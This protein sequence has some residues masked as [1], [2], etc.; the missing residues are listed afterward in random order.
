MSPVNQLSVLAFAA[1]ALAVPGFRDFGHRHSHGHPHGHSYGSAS[2][3][4]APFPA[5]NATGVW[6]STGSGFATGTSVPVMPSAVGPATVTVVPYNGDYTSSSLVSADSTS[7]CT[8]DVTVTTTERTYVTVTGT[9]EPSSVEVSATQASG[10]STTTLHVQSTVYYTATSSP[11]AA[12]ALSSSSSSSSSS[13]AAALTYSD[14]AKAHPYSHY[15]SVASSSSV[16]STSTTP[17]TSAYSTSSAVT[18]SVYSSATTVAAIAYSSSSSAVVSSSS[19]TS[20][21]S[22]S[23]TGKRGLAYNDASLTTAFEGASE[24]SWAYNWGS[25]SSG[26]SSSFKYIPLLWGT[27]SDFTSD[28]SDAA[29]SAISSGSEYLFSFNEPDLSSQANLSPEDAATAYMTYMMPFADQAKLCAPAVTNGGGAMGLTWLSE[30]MTACSDC[31]IDCVSIHWY[32]SYENSDYFKDQV[33]N[34]TSVGGGKPVFVSEFG[35]TDGSDDD[36]AGFLEEVMPW[37]GKSH[38]SDYAHDS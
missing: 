1:G 9:L 2:G 14:V 19:T 22:S 13:S 32:D 8:T 5:G 23:A 31:Q 36:I 20:S 29:S 35:C 26:L 30:F 27:S 33:T 18:S 37:M 11:V 28:W 12:S 34:A 4:G 17:V 6:G 10:G 25:S 3:S 16:E 38:R 15:S 24:V 21:S 7:E